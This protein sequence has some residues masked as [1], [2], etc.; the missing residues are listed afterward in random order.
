MLKGRGKDRVRQTG[1]ANDAIGGKAHLTGRRH[2]AAAPVAE[3]VAIGRDR[4]RRVGGQVVG[5]DD[6]RGTGEVRSEHH[7][8][9]RR[10]REIVEHFESDTNLHSKH[11]PKYILEMA[12]KPSNTRRR[13]PY[14]LKCAVSARKR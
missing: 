2:D 14:S 7:D 6:V 8:Y 4:H 9:R 1:V 5:Y 3:H 11:S 13:R 10:L 12:T